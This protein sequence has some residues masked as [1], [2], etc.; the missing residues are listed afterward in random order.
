M[1]VKELESA[2]RAAAVRAPGRQVSLTTAGEYFL[3]HAKRLLANLKDAEDAMARLQAC[4]RSAARRRP[5]QHRQVLRAAAAGA[6]RE[7][8]P[9]VEVKLQVSWPTA[10][11]WSR[12]CA[13]EVDLAIMGRPPRELATRA[14]PFAAHP[15]VFVAP[16]GHPL[17]R[18][19]ALRCRVGAGGEPFIVREIGSGTRKH[20]DGLLRR[21]PHRA[22]HHDGDAQQ[23]KH[24]AGGDGR[25]G[26]ELPV[27]AHH[28]AGS[29]Q[30]PARTFSTVQG[31][32]MMRTWNVVHLAG[33]TL[34]PAAEALR[35][36]VLA[37]HEHGEAHASARC[38][39]RTGRAR[40]LHCASTGSTS[41]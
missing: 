24:Q 7:E 26:P 14:E 18:S 29:A 4:G 1:Q 10:S 34:S 35:Y 8:H 21:T 15:Q 9:G 13:G 16:P 2:G 19:W 17:L 23:R 25:H 39:W 32:P 36:F 37:E 28:R 30:R 12:C 22:A 6:F 20:L 5:G 38:S 41:C 27:A 3:V 33:R 31:T 40:C 11:S